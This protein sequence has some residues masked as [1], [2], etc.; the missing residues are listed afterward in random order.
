LPRQA[1]VVVVGAGIVGVCAAHYLTE[2]GR[3]VLVIDQG[4]IGSGASQG[5][6][7]LVAPSH[8][9]PLAAPGVVR[10]GLRWMLDPTSPFYVR[11]RLDRD[12]AAWLARFGWSS[13]RR[14][15]EAGIAVLRDLLRHSAALFDELRQRP[16][17]EFDHGSDGVLNAYASPRAM[18]HGVAEAQ[19]LERYGLPSQ[20]LDGGQLAALE[21]ALAPSLA[22][23]VLWPEDGFVD[24]SQFV[25]QL[26]SSLERRGVRISPATELVSLAHDRGRVRRLQTTAGT[27]EAAEVVLATGAWSAALSRQLGIRLLVQPAKGYSITSDTAGPVPRRPLLLTDAKVA[28]TPLS[29]RLRLA[30][31]LELVGLDASVSWRRVEAIRDAGRR[32]LPGVTLDPQARV[33]C[34][35]RALSADGLPVIGRPGALENVTIATGHGHIGVSLGP[36]TGRLIAESVTGAGP[37]LDLRPFSPDR[38]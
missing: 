6:A 25:A 13:R 27:L 5:N 2:L 23:G 33:W 19:L 18:E 38:F 24:P 17:L 8:S 21:P 7:G 14:R 12:L 26:G 32:F 3:E 4:S 11:P 22:G 1:D 34:G 37:S 29:G 36:V 9:I 31:T 15:S 35:L 28:V 16:E 10:Q 20:V 30:G